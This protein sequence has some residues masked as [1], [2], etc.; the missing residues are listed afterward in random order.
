MNIEEFVSKYILEPVNEV[1]RII[2][3][4]F[5]VIKA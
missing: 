4:H 1:K 2:L 5:G 3:W